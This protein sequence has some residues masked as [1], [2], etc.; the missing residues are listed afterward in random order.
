MENTIEIDGIIFTLLYRSV[1]DNLYYKIKQGTE[2][3]RDHLDIGCSTMTDNTRDIV[4]FTS[5]VG[6]KKKILHAYRSTSEMGAWRLGNLR[7]RDCGLNKF[8]LDYVQGTILHHKLQKFINENFGL[9]ELIPYEQSEMEL[10][11][12]EVTIVTNPLK[13]YVY[14]N[15][16]LL[17][18]NYDK[19][20]S[21]EK[22]EFRQRHRFIMMQFPTVE[23][24]KIIDASNRKIEMP[25]FDSTTIKC[26]DIV[27]QDIIKRELYN[28][29][30]QLLT[31]YN[32]TSIK[33]VCDYEFKEPVEHIDA[34]ISMYTVDLT[35][36][37]NTENNVTLVCCIYNLLYSEKNKS[38]SG[39]Y[40]IALLKTNEIE[41]NEYGIYTKFI[42]AG[43]F[44]CKPI[45]YTRMCAL[46]TDLEERKC[47]K[48]YVYIGDRYV[49][50][51][52]YSVIP[53]MLA[54]E[55]YEK[56]ERSKK[57]SKR[58]RSRKQSIKKSRR[59]RK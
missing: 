51:F 25:P 31:M 56:K 55:G 42:S 1:A 35:C 24:I 18:N 54:M 17:K 52:P 57:R 40:G 20:D 43:V 50:I 11:V 22:K 3:W 34:R 46:M 37:E 13:K 53:Y 21:T 30:D 8:S 7:G 36:D 15:D 32:I 59:S 12:D 6:D 41:I 39:V 28:V 10:L 5:T 27:S 23:D 14:N 4:Q 49:D 29:S 47:S 33:H 9:L 38:V 19:L 26:E 48:R 16:Y 2:I 44:I 58:K 45:N